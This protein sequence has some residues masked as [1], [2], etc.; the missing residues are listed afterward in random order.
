LRPAGAGVSAD[1]DEP[2]GL[3]YLQMPAQV[4]IGQV[5]ELEKLAEEQAL[6]VGEE[7]CENAEP[8]SERAWREKWLPR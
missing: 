4:A 2:R 6:G 1:R 5:A 8:S 7:R 3:Q